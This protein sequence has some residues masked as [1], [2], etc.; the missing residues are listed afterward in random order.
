MTILFFMEASRT[1]TLIH[2]RNTSCAVGGIDSPLSNGGHQNTHV[3]RDEN[4]DITHYQNLGE[5]SVD[6]SHA[7]K[8]NDKIHIEKFILTRKTLTHTQKNERD[9]FTL[10]KL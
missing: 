7:M 2:P 4:S 1:E 9:C 5:C 3:V 6:F 8:Y 10:T